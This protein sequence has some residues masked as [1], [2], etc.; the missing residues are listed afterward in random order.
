MTN[1]NYDQF[2]ISEIELTHDQAVQ[3]KI[4][5]INAIENYGIENFE[6]RKTEIQLPTDYDEPIRVFVEFQT[7]TEY[8]HNAAPFEPTII[9]RSVHDMK[10]QLINKEGGEVKYKVLGER[11]LTADKSRF[12]TATPIDIEEE[13][14]KRFTI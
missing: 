2:S 14:I 9:D 4:D 8:E 7:F 13:V 1:M 5:V 12:Y 6:S 3:L 10:I 11:R